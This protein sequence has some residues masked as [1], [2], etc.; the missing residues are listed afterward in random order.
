[1]EDQYDYK[2]NQE[3][4]EAAYKSLIAVFELLTGAKEPEK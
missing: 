1:M 3:E 4:A 2:M